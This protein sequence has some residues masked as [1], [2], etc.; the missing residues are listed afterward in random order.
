MTNIN[1]KALE[2][3]MNAGLRTIVAG[4]PQTL[5]AILTT[6]GLGINAETGTIGVKWTLVMAVSLTQVI[7]LAISALLVMK[8]KY[9]HVDP[10]DNRNGFLPNLTK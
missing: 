8:D 3:A 2:E 5:I 4:A 9:I 1:K 7:G 6:I 10:N